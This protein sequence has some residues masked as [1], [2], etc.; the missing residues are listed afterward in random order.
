MQG[1]AARTYKAGV[2]IAFG[3]DGAASPHGANARGAV[4][5]NQAGMSEM[6]VLSCNRRSGRR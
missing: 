2:K 3:T 5:M 4:R 1:N 6:S